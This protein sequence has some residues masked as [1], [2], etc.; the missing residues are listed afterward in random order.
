MRDDGAR[1]SRALG[2]FTSVSDLELQIA[3]DSSLGHGAKRQDVSDRELGLGTGVNKHT[4]I[5]T[6]HG[7]VQEFVL[8]FVRDC[9]FASS[10]ER[11]MSER[12]RNIQ[13]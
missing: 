3:A 10:F 13:S 7:N 6:F 8:L 4:C 11:Y 12:K 1:V 5:H 9:K 2:K